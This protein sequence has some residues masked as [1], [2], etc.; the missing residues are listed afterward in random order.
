M[1]IPANLLY[2]PDH[3]WVLIEGNIATVGVTAYATDQLGDIVY[4][5]I[6]TVGESLRAHEAFGTVEAVKTVSDLFMPLAGRVVE[7]NPLLA[8]Q[9]EIVN[10]QP[11]GDGWMIKIEMGP[12]SDRTGL[13]TADAYRAAIGA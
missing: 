6:N 11:Y 1:E 4:V 2:T 10:Q 8:T 13:L 7:V 3:E 5:E 12:E 9:P